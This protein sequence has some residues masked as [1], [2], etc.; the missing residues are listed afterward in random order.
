VMLSFAR[1]NQGRIAGWLN[2]LKWR[3]SPRPDAAGGD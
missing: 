2:E 1:A 3:M